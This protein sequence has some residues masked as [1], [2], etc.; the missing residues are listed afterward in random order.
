[1]FHKKNLLS[2]MLVVILISGMIGIATAEVK[3][4]FTIENEYEKAKKYEAC[5]LSHKKHAEE[6]TDGKENKIGCVGCHHVYKDEKNVLHEEKKDG[7]IVLKEG[8]KIVTVQK[9][10]ACHSGKANLKPNEAKKLPKEKM[11]NERSWAYHEKCYGC[12]KAVKAANKKTNAPSSCG[13]CHKR[14]K[15]NK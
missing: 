8:D 6:Y 14:I 7:K 13:K 12:H 1:M 5:P 10:T 15:G 4:T 11:E 2:F 9:C 3:D